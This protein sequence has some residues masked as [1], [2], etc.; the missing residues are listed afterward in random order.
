MPADHVRLRALD[1]HVVLRRTHP[2]L[3]PAQSLRRRHIQVGTVEIL[4]L[5]GGNP[6]RMQVAR[7]AAGPGL[8]HRAPDALA[9]GQAVLRLVDFAASVHLLRAHALRNGARGGDGVLAAQR[10]EAHLERR[11]LGAGADTHGV[12]CTGVEGR[13][14]HLVTAESGIVRAVQSRRTADAADDRMRP[15]NVG[16]TVVHAETHGTGNARRA[17]GSP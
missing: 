11:H 6:L 9:G 10:D 17:A 13:I 1:L 4:L 8:L 3:Y 16:T 7:P 15:D 12:S 14:P 5:I 2:L